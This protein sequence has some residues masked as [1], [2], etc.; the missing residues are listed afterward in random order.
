MKQVL[1][2][3]NFIITCMK[4]KIDFFEEIP[5]IG[6][7]IIIPQEVIGELQKLKQEQALRLLKKEEDKFSKISLQG[8]NV[9]NAIIN[10]A[11]KNPETIIATLDREIKTKIKNRKMIIR[12]K[13]K[14][15]II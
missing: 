14:L 8:K 4:H 15:E 3:T 11:N 7:P 10:F 6:I 13:S 9:D 5:L 12:D 2:D 1:L